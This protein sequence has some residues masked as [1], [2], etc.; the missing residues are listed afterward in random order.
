MWTWFDSCVRTCVHMQIYWKLGLVIIFY[1]VCGDDIMCGC[2]CVSYVNIRLKIVNHIHI[3][4]E[5]SQ[6][7]YIYM[8]TVQ[9]I[10][11][12]QQRNR[13]T[14]L[15]TSSQCSNGKKSAWSRAGLA[16]SPGRQKHTSGWG[17][18]TLDGWCLVEKCQVS[19]LFVLCSDHTRQKSFKTHHDHWK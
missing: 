1:I 3:H 12:H 19:C 4:G 11:E 13:W 15:K 16:F 6:S 17:K 10:F 8:D 5:I 2:V 14:K 9:M 7:I 18:K